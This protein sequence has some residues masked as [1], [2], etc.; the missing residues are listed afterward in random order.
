MRAY[1]FRKNNQF[2]LVKSYEALQINK[3]REKKE[4]LG[5]LCNCSNQ[6]ILLDVY[7]ERIPQ[8][9]SQ[10]PQLSFPES[11]KVLKEATVG[12]E[13]AYQKVGGLHIN[14]ELIGIN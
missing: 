7:T 9:L 10:L 4:Y 13:A 1:S 12:F 5:D 8:R 6:K 11:L 14:P 3:D 2:G